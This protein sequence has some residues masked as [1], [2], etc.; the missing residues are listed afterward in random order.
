MQLPRGALGEVGR[1]AAV[2]VKA[3]SAKESGDVRM[4]TPALVKASKPSSAIPIYL[5]HQDVS[6]SSSSNII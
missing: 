5:A 6:S 4:A 1:L 3:E 2:P